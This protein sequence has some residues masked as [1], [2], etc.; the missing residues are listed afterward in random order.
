[1]I[2]FHTDMIVLYL[3]I[4]ICLYITPTFF[5]SFSPIT[6][7]RIRERNTTQR[8]ES[9]DR[10]AFQPTAATNCQMHPALLGHQNPQQPIMFDLEQ[11]FKQISIPTFVPY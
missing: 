6:R 9:P 11:V 5:Y 7:R 4:Y 2:T 8:S 10:R 1:M 3:F